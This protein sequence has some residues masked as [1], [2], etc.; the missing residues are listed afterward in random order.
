MISGDVR[1]FFGSQGPLGFGDDLKLLLRNLDRK[2]NL[3]HWIASESSRGRPVLRAC[4]EY[5]ELIACASMMSRRCA[6]LAVA[7]ALFFVAVAAQDDLADYP[8]KEEQCE[9]FGECLT[10]CVKKLPPNRQFTEIVTPLPANS[11]RCK[12]TQHTLESSVEYCRTPPSRDL[13]SPRPPLRD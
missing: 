10:E 6:A 3:S 7:V 12:P 11:S 2:W 13:S 5:Q 1:D 9:N 4:G 8:I